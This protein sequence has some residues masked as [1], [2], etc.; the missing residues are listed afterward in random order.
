MYAIAK[1]RMKGLEGPLELFSK[2]IADADQ[3]DVALA[4]FAE[5]ISQEMKR[6]GYDDVSKDKAGNVVGII[7]GYEGKEDITLISHI[8]S[9][10]SQEEGLLSFKAG[11]I[12]SLYAGALLKRSLLPIS[13]DLIVCCVPRGDCCDFGVKYL[14]ENSL[15]KR[16]GRLKGVV[17]SEPTDLNVNLGHKGRMEYEIVV[18]GRIDRE[19]LENKGINMLG[20][21][22][23]LI[24]ELEKV[25]H[26]LPSDFS[27][28]ASSLKIKDISY[29]GYQPQGEEKE[30]RLIVDR[31][32]VPE[33]ET[34][35]ILKRAKSI[36]TLIYKGEPEIAINTALSKSRIRTYT[37]LDI[38]SEKEFKPWKI[39]NNHP[40]V[41]SSLEV[42]KD[43]GFG[44]QL[45]YW[46]RIV[47]EGSYT[48]GELKI[49]TIG[50]GIGREELVDSPSGSLAIDELERA[51]F[52]QV[53]I[54]HR[55][56]GMPTFGWSADEI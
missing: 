10:D 30:F 44:S 4:E 45:G 52:G 25:S 35:A 1:K 56:I 36:A 22:F 16:M 26:T 28:G 48:F 49:P 41:T 19:F 37:G 21:M 46:K 53:L 13:G 12:S 31:A 42:L 55:S 40:F 39:E 5:L 11:I 54:A 20:T 2:K 50:F 14:F 24:N 51:I 32:F 23:P 3:K 29:S 47:T 8:G 18:K 33:E 27:L 15:K 38:V 6:L 7:R 34:G 43:N 9:N 17:L